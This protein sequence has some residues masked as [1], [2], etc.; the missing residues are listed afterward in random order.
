MKMVN[1][2]TYVQLMLENERQYYA[3]PFC[4][5]SAQTSFEVLLVLD[6]LSLMNEAVKCKSI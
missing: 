2:G 4:S 1:A 6:L 3:S 5:M